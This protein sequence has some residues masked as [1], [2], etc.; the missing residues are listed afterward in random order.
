MEYHI[1]PH[2][3]LALTSGIKN[4]SRI[5]LSMAKYNNV[6]ACFN[7][8]KVSLGNTKIVQFGIKNGSRVELDNEVRVSK[9]FTPFEI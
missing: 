5:L 2:F 3:L 7:Y 1:S 9:S 8:G 6:F 4:S